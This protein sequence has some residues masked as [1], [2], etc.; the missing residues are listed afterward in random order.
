[1]MPIEPTEEQAKGMKEIEEVLLR[2]GLF[3]YSLSRIYCKEGN[4]WGMTLIE[5]DR[6]KPEMNG[7]KYSQTSEGLIPIDTTQFK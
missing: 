2:N 7:K 1:M 5:I 6:H 3:I 4:G